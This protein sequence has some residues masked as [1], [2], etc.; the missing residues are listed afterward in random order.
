MRSEAWSNLMDS[1][2]GPLFSI[3]TFALGILVTYVFYRKSRRTKEPCWDMRTHNLIAGYSARLSELEVSFSGKRVENLSISRIAFW[4]QG[5]ET[6]HGTEIPPGSPLRI[7]TKDARLLDAKILQK[8]HESCDFKVALLGDGTAALLTFGYCDN[9]QG[10]V[11]QIV[12]TGIGTEDL[13]LEGILKG[14]R[15][16]T[17]RETLPHGAFLI[18]G[19]LTLMGSAMIGVGSI[20][21]KQAIDSLLIAVGIILLFA[22]AFT[23]GR[24]WRNRLPSGL[25]L[26][27]E[28]DA[29]SEKPCPGVGSRCS[30]R[31]SRPAQ[32]IQTSTRRLRA[33]PLSSELQATGASSPKPLTIGVFTPRSASARATVSARLFERSR[34]FR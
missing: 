1:L 4:N 29:F 26:E 34:L 18:M 5:T 14:S 32:R 13:M 9:G 24:F 25:E 7:I 19:V 33:L 6:I 31:L 21:P 3:L 10:V 15:S 2:N 30:S 11:L 28:E 12:H 17:R 16:L 8:K 27:E 20:E 23:S 22:A